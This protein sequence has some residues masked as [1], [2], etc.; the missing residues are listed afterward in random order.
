MA[1]N[2]DQGKYN[3]LLRRIS[4]SCVKITVKNVVQASSHDY[5]A[6]LKTDMLLI[7]DKKAY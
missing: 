3:E 1:T 2:L 5:I 7:A 4:H 6:A